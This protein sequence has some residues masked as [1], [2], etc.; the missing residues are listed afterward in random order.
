MRRQVTFLDR[1]RQ[2]AHCCPT[3]P[4]IA[5]VCIYWKVQSSF[6]CTLESTCEGPNPF[7]ARRLSAIHSRGHQ[8]CWLIRYNPVPGVAYEKRGCGVPQHKRMTLLLRDQ[9]GAS[10]WGEWR[11]LNITLFFSNFVIRT[12]HSAR[13]WLMSFKKPQ[14]EMAHW[15][16][17]LQ[18]YNFTMV[19]SLASNMWMQ[20]H[21]YASLVLLIFATAPAT[22]TVR[23]GASQGFT[24]VD[25]CEWRLNQS[26]KSDTREARNTGRDQLNHLDNTVSFPG[27]GVCI[28]VIS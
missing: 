22:A 12:D 14:G 7:F 3:F 27:K 2:S 10:F 25:A 13:Q 9:T 20:M 15:I 24:I 26:E 1:M 5:K 16:R 6:C 28:N 18:T 21:F 4:A 11:Y 17:E 8:E 23:R 19:H